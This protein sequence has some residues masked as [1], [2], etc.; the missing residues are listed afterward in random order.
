MLNEWGETVLA[1]VRSLLWALGITV[2]AAS[3]GSGSAA[4]G[5]NATVIVTANFNPSATGQNTVFTASVTAAGLPPT[6]VVDFLDGF[7]PLCT[8]VPLVS[9]QASC[10]TRALSSGT[11]A[12]T[13]VYRGDRNYVSITSL[14]YAQNVDGAFANLLIVTTGGS[15]GGSVT[16][17]P[18]GIDCAAQ[19]R[20][21]YAIAAAVTLRA[22]PDVTS[23]FTGWSGPCSG[24]GE[25]RVNVSAITSVAATFASSGI[26]PLRIDIDANTAYDPLTD[27]LIIARYLF[28]LRGTAMTSGALGAGA[29]R[30]DPAE[31]LAHL[32]DL[33]PALDID[34]NGESD[35]LTDGLMITR[36]LF[37]LRGNAL[38]AGALGARATRTTAAQIEGY[39]QSLMPTPVP[40]RG[41]A[42]SAPEK[43][44]TFVPFADAACDDSSTTGVGISLSTSSNGVL[45]FLNGGGAC[46][47]EVTCLDLNGAV[48]GP[49]GATQFNGT[50]GALNASWI[51][52]RADA[53]NPFKDYSFV[54]VPYC[55]GDWH[56]GNNIVQYRGRPYRHTGFANMSAFLN[57]IVPTFPAAGPVFLA[58]TSAGGYGAAFNWWQTQQRFGSTRVHMID[59]SGPFMPPDTVYPDVAAEQA[60]RLNWNLD[61]TLPAG[62]LGCASSLDKIFNF[63]TKAFPNNRA[64]LVSHTEDL[65]VAGYYGITP[66]LFTTGLLELVTAQIRPNPK[67]RSFLISGSGHS[68]LKNSPQSAA[69]GG[70]GLSTFITQMV[71]DDPA[72]ASRP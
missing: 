27:G 67:F 16:S 61:A 18:P 7:T 71:N 17:N 65:T 32:N 28:G 68:S 37:G 12:I 9:A 29:T 14:P 45:I 22:T 50:V 4:A 20:E 2:C 58:G 30:T 3:V 10:V 8:G 41:S 11:H 62:C 38:L 57:R 72:W 31:V 47:D 46:W 5:A 70:V 34:G 24:T 44:W 6:G 1:A 51:F 48:H 59:D 19:C 13:A 15:G 36:Y 35:A 40:P 55:T 42:M 63:Y 23:T 25:C 64:A 54:F 21:P 60:R 49:F 56:A 33:K 26:V 43:T 53:T 52:N 39:I 66:G 69:S